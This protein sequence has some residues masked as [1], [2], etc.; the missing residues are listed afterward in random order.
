MITWINELLNYSIIIRALI[1]A[2]TEAHIPDLSRLTK[3]PDK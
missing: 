1:H 3:N 2:Y